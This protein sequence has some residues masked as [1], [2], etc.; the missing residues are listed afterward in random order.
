MFTKYGRDVILR[1]L[2]I[3]ILLIVL[4]Y[5]SH[6]KILEIILLVV[7]VLF[8]IFMFYFFRDPE[9]NPP[10]LDDGEIVSPADGKVVLIKEIEFVGNEFFNAGE[11]LIQLS[12]FLSP[13]NVHINRFPMS[14][15]L[16]Y[17]KY[18]PGKYLVAFDDKSSL[19][20]E[21][22]EFGIE[23][24]GKKLLFKQIAGFI[25]RRI[26][27]DCKENSQ[28]KAGDRFGMIKFGSRMD[29]LF[30]PG[31]KIYVN[32]GDKVKAGETKLLKLIS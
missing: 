7:V 31:A 19:N 5:L 12:I 23:S 28:V 1:V 3:S 17:V 10:H 26:V 21:R 15:T 2:V 16:K 24:G 11:K 22:S 27:Y 25:A 30:K 14:G 29:L 32:L 13:L 4:G 9:R 20:N 18:I 8:N 6:N